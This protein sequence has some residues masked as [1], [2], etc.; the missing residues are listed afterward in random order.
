M[1]FTILANVIILCAWGR[2]SRTL[3]QAQVLHYYLCRVTS[4]DFTF[5]CRSGGGSGFTP[6]PTRPDGA[7]QNSTIHAPFVVC[8]CGK[9]AVIRT[10]RQPRSYGDI[11]YGCAHDRSGCNYFSWCFM[12]ARTQQA[13]RRATEAAFQERERD[14]ED[15]GGARNGTQQGQQGRSGSFRPI[16]PSMRALMNANSRDTKPSR[17]TAAYNSGGCIASRATA[18]RQRNP[19]PV[20]VANSFLAR[21]SLKISIPFLLAILRTPRHIPM[22]CWAQF[23]FI[24]TCIQS[25]FTCYRFTFAHSKYVSCSWFFCSASFVLGGSFGSFV[26][27]SLFLTNISALKLCCFAALQHLPRPCRLQEVSPLF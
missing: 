19:P 3:F 1:L 12:H 22:E 5:D 26:L 24:N 23:K 14:R 27:G 13:A 25:F 7:Q 20:C 6:A 18:E 16:T 9:E 10:S 15:S 8:H 17:S 21:L 2:G 4:C 11:F